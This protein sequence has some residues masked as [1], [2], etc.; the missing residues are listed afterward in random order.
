MSQVDRMIAHA[1]RTSHLFA[2]DLKTVL[3]DGADGPS[4]L[5]FFFFL[6]IVMFYANKTLQFV[7][8]GIVV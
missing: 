6:V 2:L 5:D 1:E 3:V 4:T 8:F 7:T